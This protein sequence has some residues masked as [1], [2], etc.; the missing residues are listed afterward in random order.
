MDLKTLELS[1]LVTVALF[2]ALAAWALD[3]VFFGSVFA[4][5]IAVAALGLAKNH[6]R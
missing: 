4:A 1:L 2:G 3:D 5:F 6:W